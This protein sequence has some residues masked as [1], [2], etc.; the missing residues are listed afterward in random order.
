[1]C[2]ISF[3][4]HAFFSSAN[5]KNMIRITH[6]WHL[7]SNCGIDEH[8]KAIYLRSFQFQ[9]CGRMITI[10]HCIGFFYRIR[11]TFHPNSEKHSILSTSV[12]LSMEHSNSEAY[13]LMFPSII[14]AV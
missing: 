8:F 13:N 7:R 11:I 14:T 2:A 3:R 6:G 1:M 5:S 4:S 9:D 10:A 12:I